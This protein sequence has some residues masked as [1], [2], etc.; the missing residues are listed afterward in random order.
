MNYYRRYVG[1]YL[2]DTS[3]L[4]VLEHG[5]YNLLLDYYYADEKPLPLERDEIY[6]MVRAM[7]GADR[8]AVDK[9]IR[10]YFTEEPDGYHQKRV[11]HEILVSQKARTNG[12]SG[13]RPPAHIKPDSEPEHKPD[14]EPESEPLNETEQETGQTTETITGSGHPPTTNHQPPAASLQPPAEVRRAEARRTPKRNASAVDP[15][16]AFPDVAPQVLSDWLAIRKDKRASTLTRTAADEIRAEAVKAGLSMEQCLR[17]CCKRHWVGFG[18]GWNWQDSVNGS[19]PLSM[20]NKSA[21]IE[22]RNRAAAVEALRE[23]GDGRG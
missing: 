17:I 21:A 14:S 9:I 3:R 7:S 13:G 20:G 16:E 22:E 5:A 2:R 1:D 19:P 4:S 10:L 12:K 6:T 11:D 15:G 18:A 8:K 23:V